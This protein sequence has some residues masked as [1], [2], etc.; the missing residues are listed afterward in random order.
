M[1]ADYDERDWGK[2]EEGRKGMLDEELRGN[3]RAGVAM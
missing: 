3:F 1:G 2:G